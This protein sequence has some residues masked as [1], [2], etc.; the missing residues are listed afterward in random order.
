MF[1]LAEFSKIKEAAFIN[2]VSLEHVMQMK[3]LK[4]HR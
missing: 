4:I 2:R 3:V 1:K